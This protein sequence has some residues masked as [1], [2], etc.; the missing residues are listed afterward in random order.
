ML[1]AR[2]FVLTATALLVALIV[3]AGAQLPSSLAPGWLHRQ[4]DTYQAIWPQRWSYFAT[5]DGVT[6]TGVYRPGA[7]NGRYAV[8]TSPLTSADNRWGLSQIGRASCRERV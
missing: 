7:G 5:P 6:T 8:A 1:S 4:H 3:T 2:G